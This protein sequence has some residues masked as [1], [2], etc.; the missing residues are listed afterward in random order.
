MKIIVLTINLNLYFPERVRQELSQKHDAVFIGNKTPLSKIKELYDDEEKVVAIDPDFCDWQLDKST[1]TR[2]KNVKA[3]CL[4]STSYSWIDLQEAK[5]QNIIITNIRNWSTNSVA[6]KAVTM[7]L[8]LARKT[9]LLLKRKG[10]ID[11]RQLQ[12]LMGMEIKGETVGIIGLGHIGKRIAEIMSGL[13]AKVVY[14]SRSSRDK[15]FVFTKIDRLFKESDFVFPTVIQNSKTKGLITNNLIR[16]MKKT[17]VFISIM[18]IFSSRYK[19]YNHKFVLDLVSKKKIFGY[20]FEHNDST[21]F[22]YKGNVWVTPELA[23]YTKESLQRNS[24]QWVDVILKAAQE[25]YINSVKPLP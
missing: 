11:F 3:I 16:E 1:I 4:Q 21:I 13:G 8:N 22:D 5:K 18:P 2:F 12:D 23:W 19:V 10:R 17:S 7:A 20:G 15:R 9:P 14:W 6:E 25:K 24:A